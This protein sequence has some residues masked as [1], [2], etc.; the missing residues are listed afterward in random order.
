MVSS[1]E[2][3]RSCPRVG[4]VVWLLLLFGGGRFWLV[5]PALCR[6]VDFEEDVTADLEEEFG[7]GDGNLAGVVTGKLEVG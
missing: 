4:A 3:E 5:F 6:P 7:Y 1:L 2:E